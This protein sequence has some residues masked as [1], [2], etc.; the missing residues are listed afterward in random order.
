[1]LLKSFLR[2]DVARRSE[3]KTSVLLFIII[4]I[5]NLSPAHGLPLLSTNS[6]LFS[7]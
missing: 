3:K 6:R 1:M 7:V 2:V 5:T 4:L